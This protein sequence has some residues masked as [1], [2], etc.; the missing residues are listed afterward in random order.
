MTE[1]DGLSDEVE[2]T[3]KSIATLEKA[4]KIKAGTVATTKAVKA[5]VAVVTV[6]KPVEKSA[7]AD[8]IV[9]SAV[10][11]LDAK[12]KGENV[13][14]IIESRYGKDEFVKSAKSFLNY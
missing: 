9:K 8:F 5:N 10:V 13:E 14:S 6:E 7:V 3:T 2:V 4:E 1:I 12:A 11:M